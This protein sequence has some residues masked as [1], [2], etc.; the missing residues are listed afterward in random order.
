MGA[1][2]MAVVDLAT[3]AR[4]GG[5]RKPS[6]DTATHLE[7]YRRFPRIGGIAHTH[8]RW[9]TVFAQAER[10]IP[11]LGTTHADH[12]S[13][14][15]PCTRL[16]TEAEIRGEYELETGRVIAETFENTAV[17]PDGV[18]AVLV[19]RH[20]PFTWGKDAEEAARNSA[21]LEEAAFM[22]WHTLALSPQIAPLP[23]TL[24]EK[25]FARKHGANKYYGQ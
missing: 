4:V 5:G 8:S 20:G 21:V 3:G 9:A 11:A 14:G 6:S 16:L 19:A 18:P 13:G 15:V 17:N 12:F 10:G 1:D 2:D 22:A 7:L 24:L 23:P 25:H